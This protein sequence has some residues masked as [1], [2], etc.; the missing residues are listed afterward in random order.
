MPDTQDRLWLR[1]FHAV[2]AAWRA[3]FTPLVVGVTGSIAAY[4]AVELV[5]TFVTAGAVVRVVMT[6]AA[7]RFV[8]PLTFQSVT[9]RPARL[10]LWGDEAHVIH[11]GLA[12]S[13]DLMLIAPATAQTLAKLA[14]GLADTVDVFFDNV[15]GETLDTVL[16]LVNLR[17]RIVVC[18][19]ISQYNATEPYGVKMFRSILVNRLKVQGMIVFDWLERYPEANQALLELVLS[20]KLKTRE[21]VVDGIENAP[22]GL[23]GL[24]MAVIVLA[25][26]SSTASELNALGTTSTPARF[27]PSSRTSGM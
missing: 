23:V 20:G 5:R 27:F 11:V 17:A 19:F 13:A 12:E 14:H 4:K 8:T 1:A 21:S 22:K 10:D 7:Q 3:R 2:A 24:L 26:M 16:S 25:S 6:D 9:G 15:G 18:G